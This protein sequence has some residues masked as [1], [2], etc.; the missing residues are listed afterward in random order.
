MRVWVSVLVFT[1]TRLEER[2][3]YI[4]PAPTACRFPQ[5]GMGSVEDALAPGPGV[6]SALGTSPRCFPLG[7]TFPLNHDR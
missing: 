5:L 3:A 6:A 1:P 4:S 2:S 7:K